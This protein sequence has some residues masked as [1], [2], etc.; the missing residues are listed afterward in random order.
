[1]EEGVQVVLLRRSWG[2][3]DGN[4]VKQEVFWIYQS[5]NDDAAV[6][7]G[8]AARRSLGVSHGVNGS[9]IKARYPRWCCLSVQ[10]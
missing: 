4:G 2:L 7:N 8:L 10:M 5:T 9:M 3:Q 1:M 6:L